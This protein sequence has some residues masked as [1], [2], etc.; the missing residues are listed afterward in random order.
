MANAT[1]VGSVKGN[2]SFVYNV[3]DTATQVLAAKQIKDN[4]FVELLHKNGKGVTEQTE[5]D[6]SSIRMLKYVPLTGSARALGAGTNGGYFNTADADFGEVTEY[7]LNL[8][9]IFDKMLDIP[10]VQ[11]DMC[12]ANLF[13]AATKNIAGR[14]HTEINASTLAEQ[15]KAVYNAVGAMSTPAWANH[16]VVLSSTP[17]HYESLLAASSMLD[18]GD[19]T[20][21]IQTFPVEEREFICK[22]SYRTGL[23]STNG[24]II[25][26]SNYAQSMLAKGGVDPEA[27]RENGTCYVGEIDMVPVFVA[28]A[29]IWNR[30]KAWLDADGKTFIDNVEG[31]LCSAIATDRGI[32]T[33]DYVKII[34]SPKGAG[35]RLQPKVRWGINVCY[36][37]GIVPILKNG[38]SAPASGHLTI[39]VSAPGNV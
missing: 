30:A 1:A 32:S 35:K 13:D 37:K 17:K 10:E 25:G 28:P 29:P 2:A 6:V 3:N 33:P 8:L 20:N 12:P 11:Q 5:T 14:I 9:Y 15:V 23:M 31:L 7:D 34:D 38:T 27:R 24:V 16:A 4:I 18:D 39:A 22:T 36:D 21:G 26:G 19:E